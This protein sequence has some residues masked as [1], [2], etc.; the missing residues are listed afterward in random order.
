MTCGDCGKVQRG[1][2]SLLVKTEWQTAIAQQVP[3]AEYR[4]IA[5]L[6]AVPRIGSLALAVCAAC[7]RSLRI[8]EQVLT[9]PTRTS[10]SFAPPTCR[11]PLGRASGFPRTVPGGRVTP[12]FD[13]A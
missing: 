9:F 8:G 6:G 1:Q 10:L 3:E 4:E 7:D 12:G 13:I 2:L 5:A 11:M